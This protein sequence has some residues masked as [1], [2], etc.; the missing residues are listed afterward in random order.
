VGDDASLA[1]ADAAASDG[2]ATRDASNASDVSAGA[3]PDA[4]PI[5]MSRGCSCRAGPRSVASSL[6]WLAAIGGAAF[7]RR[8]TRAR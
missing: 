5:T 4:R 7:V 6:A 2:G 8:R 1:T 3:A